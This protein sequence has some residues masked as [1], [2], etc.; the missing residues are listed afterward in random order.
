[1]IGDVFWLDWQ[2]LN[3]NELKRSCLDK[4]S[5]GIRVDRDVTHAIIQYLKIFEYDEI[6]LTTSLAKHWRVHHNCF[7][8][9]PRWAYTH[10]SVTKYVILK[11]IIG[12]S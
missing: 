9:I 7:Q 1:M 3:S 8:S 2:L 12:Q 5:V 6:E 4:L 10:K 11:I